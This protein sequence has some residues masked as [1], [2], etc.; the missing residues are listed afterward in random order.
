[1]GITCADVVPYSAHI[2]SYADTWGWVMVSSF[3][4]TFL[5]L[6]IL[7]C[8]I[9]NMKIYFLLQIHTPFCLVFFKVYIIYLLEMRMLT[10][11]PMMTGIRFT[12][13]AECWWTRPQNQAEDQRGEQIPR[14]QNIYI[15]LYLEQSCSKIVSPY[16]YILC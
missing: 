5:I 9:C 6:L 12:I 2:P 14:W 13:H 1:M 11:N 4:G 16:P 10:R 3:L 15:I 8:T 7:I